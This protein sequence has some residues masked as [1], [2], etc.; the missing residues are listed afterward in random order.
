MRTGRSVGSPKPGAVYGCFT[1][2]HFVRMGPRRQP[3]WLVHCSVCDTKQE[4]AVRPLMWRASANC[5]FCQ[6]TNMVD[7]SGKTFGKVTVLSRDTE[8]PIGRDVFW[9]V[10]C[11]CGDEFTVRSYALQAGRKEYHKCTK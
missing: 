9:R 4:R 5:K 3:V 2:C 7:K 11:E 8:K 6:S 1:L 10:R